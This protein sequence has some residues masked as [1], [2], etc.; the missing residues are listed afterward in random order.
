MLLFR[1][2]AEDRDENI[3]TEKNSPKFWTLE[4][5]DYFFF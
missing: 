3:E 2:G 4:I 5:F 1:V